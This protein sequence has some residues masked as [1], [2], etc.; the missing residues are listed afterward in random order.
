MSQ[1]GWRYL[2]AGLAFGL[3][4][5]LVSMARSSDNDFDFNPITFKVGPHS[6]IDRPEVTWEV[7]AD[8]QHHCQPPDTATRGRGTY[9]S[10]CMVWD[11][12]KNTCAI[13]T[14][15]KTTHAQLGHLL[16]AC[17]EKR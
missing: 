10:G 8:P 15:K 13:F 2:A 12:V 4:V 11:Q 1:R 7:S 6:R 14:T 3:S 16:I 9:S 17:M 5:P